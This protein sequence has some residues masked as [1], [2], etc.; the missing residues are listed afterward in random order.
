M[1]PTDVVLADP[2]PVVVSGFGSVLEKHPVIRVVREV[3]TLSDLEEGFALH[4]GRLVFL[5]G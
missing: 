1:Q 4:E 2:S 3:T 5:L